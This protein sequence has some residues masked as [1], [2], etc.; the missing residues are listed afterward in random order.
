MS[1]P[2]CHGFGNIGE[3]PHSG[4]TIDCPVCG[5]EGEAVPDQIQELRDH[6]DSLESRIVLLEAQL[7]ISIKAEAAS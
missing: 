4:A 1:C 2:R 6:I 7:N 3:E 5:G